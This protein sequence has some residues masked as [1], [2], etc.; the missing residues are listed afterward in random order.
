MQ[1]I[2]IS[3]FRFPAILVLIL[4]FFSFRCIASDEPDSIANA[5]RKQANKIALQSAILPGLGQVS[6]HK[7][8]KV[9]IIYGGFAALV[10]FIDFNNK[11]YKDYK[12]AYLYRNDNDSLTVDAFPNFTTDDIRVRKDYYRRNRDLSYILTAVLYSL[13]IID[14]YVDA[15]LRNF[16]ISEDL[17]L[18]TDPFVGQLNQG[19]PIAG[20]RFTF[21]LK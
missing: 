6:N 14:A 16:D 17:S 9:P 15:Q 12:T 8:W 3:L 5:Q 21:T 2:S 18:R 13:N 1:G 20:L 19:E 4:F 10:Y 7:Y 11:N